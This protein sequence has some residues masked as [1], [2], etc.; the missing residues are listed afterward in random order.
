MR[1]RALLLA[2][3][4]AF[5]AGA[6]GLELKARS[7]SS[8]KQFIVYCDDHFLRTRV[9][10]FCDEVKSD[11][12]G[13]LN[14]ADSW[15]I[16]VLIRLE[17]T[18]GLIIGGSPVKLQFIETPDGARIQLDVQIGDD[19][20]A[21]NLQK[22]IVRVVLLEHAYRE[23]GGVRAG[24]SYYEAP[25]WLIE[26]AVQTFRRRDRGV[27]TD[28]F[29]RLIETNKLPPIEEFLTLREA[30]PGS[31][32]EAVDATCAMCLVQ[33]LTEQP[34][35]KANLARLLRQWPEAQGDSVAALAKQFPAFT[36]RAN[37]Q[38]WWT[39]NLARFS[40]ADRYKGLSAEETNQDLDKLLQFE[41]VADKKGE[42]KP[43]T[44]AQ[45][46]EFSRLPGNKAAMQ[47]LRADLT[48]LSTRA[49]AI[50][51]P[52]LDDYSSLA[53]QLARGKTRGVAER[54]AQIEL[55]RNSVLNR[56][57]DIGDYL[58]WFEATQL[59]T[60][61]GAFDSYLKA[62]NEISAQE[63]RRS[64]PITEYMDQLQQEF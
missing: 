31:T 22:Q 34:G 56:M 41:V 51:R 59:G 24:E 30:E 40:A 16:P 18:S 35:G 4:L 54:I 43:F 64:T 36:Q 13:L 33:L 14:E 2:L 27:D 29:R 26:G 42:K 20:A 37:L 25:W 48:A 12:L 45:F 32:A 8:S 10:S 57:T 1:A 23:K 58:N 28:F 52:V 38:R 3:L 21:V 55:Y 15:K 60:R 44:L 50:L 61:S 5:S 47:Q 39:L 17:R 7:I 9:A 46:E 49:N 53:A 11:V 19:P 63:S 6:D 62:A